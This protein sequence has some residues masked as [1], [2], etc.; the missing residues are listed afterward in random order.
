MII[1]E[2]N[3]IFVHIPKTAGISLTHA[4]MS[5]IVGTDTSGEIGHLSNKLKIRFELRGK[6]KHK[7]AY[8][9]VPADISKELWDNYYK[10]AFIRNPWDRAVSEF[11]WRHTLLTRK[12]SKNFKE[13]LG[14]CER[15]LQNIDKGIYWTHAQTQK[16]YVTNNIGD[17]ILNDLFKF[18]DMDNNIKII[19]DK[20]NITL[21]MKKY[22]SSNHKHYRKYYNCETEEIVRRLYKEDIEMFN[23]EF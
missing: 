9:Y 21:N 12:P 15:R 6:Q 18:E 2:C 20:L 5:H 8:N 19:S 7:Q 13:F 3:A 11:H 4:I 14:H 22:N 16:S 23:Y 1:H 17:I 10:F